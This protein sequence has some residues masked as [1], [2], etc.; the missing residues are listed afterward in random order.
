MTALIR[1]AATA[2]FTA[3]PLSPGLAG[4]T[5]TTY[6]DIGRYALPAGAAILSLSQNDAEGFKQLLASG[7]VTLSATYALKYAVDDTRPNGGRRSFPSGHTAWAFT[8]AAFIHQR[9][10]WA[11]G[12][13]AEL[14]ATAVAVSRVDGDF[15]RWRDV[16]ASAVIA[17]ASAY[18]LVDRIDEN[19]TLLPMVG[20]RKP[21]FG[22]VGSLRF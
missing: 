20:G 7:A 3:L 8:G 18:F 4:E 1:F 13:P 10:G 17:H 19:V 5:F 15:H 22:I 14:A 9:Y 2:A 16:I 12:V 21:A 11:W 6:G